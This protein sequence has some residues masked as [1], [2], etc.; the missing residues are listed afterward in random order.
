MWWREA[1][2]LTPTKYAASLLAAL[3][4]CSCSMSRD[5]DIARRAVEQFHQR[6]AAGQDDTVYDAADPIYKQSVSREINHGLLWRIRRKMGSC[7]GSENTRY[8]VNAGTSGTFVT[9]QYRTKCANGEL[10][11]EFVWHV[12]EEG[13]ALVSYRANSPLLLAD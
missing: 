10:D 12:E 1:V 6:L 4:L 8:F 11:E 5:R 3:L 9:L 7:Q 2:L 13:A